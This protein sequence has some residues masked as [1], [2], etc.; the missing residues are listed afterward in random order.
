[1]FLSNLVLLLF[2]LKKC[3][4]SHFRG[5]TISWRPVD[6]YCSSNYCQISITSR[7][8]Y[9]YGMF[10]CNTPSQINAGGSLGGGSIASKNGP[11]WSVSAVVYCTGFSIQDQWQ[12]GTN[13]QTAS[14]ISSYAVTAGFSSWYEKAYKNS[15]HVQLFFK[16]DYTEYSVFPNIQNFN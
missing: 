3:E 12:A 9:I 11:Y 4:S 2:V 5:G 6:P 10:P 13:V 16:N 15:T 1:M 7:F 14:V 8:Y